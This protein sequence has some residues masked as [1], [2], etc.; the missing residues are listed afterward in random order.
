MANTLQKILARM[1]GQPQAPVAYGTGP[2]NLPGMMAQLPDIQ[3]RQTRAAKLR[4]TQEKFDEMAKKQEKSNYTPTQKGGLYE[5]VAQ[6][7]TDYSGLG[8]ELVGAIGGHFNEK[9]MEREDA[10]LKN[11]S[12]NEQLRVLEQIGQQR[13]R[14]P[15]TPAPAGEPT[16]AALRGYLGM[17]GGDIDKGVFSDAA[18]VSGQIIEK[19]TGEVINR[20][21]D[22]S[23][24][25]TGIIKDPNVKILDPEGEVIQVVDLGGPNVGTGRDVIFGGGQPQPGQPQ[26]GQPQPGQPQRPNTEQTFRDSL[27]ISPEQEAQI[28]LIEAEQGAPLTEQQMVQYLQT[29]DIGLPTPGGQQQPMPQGAPNVPAQMPEPVPGGAQ[30]AAAGAPAP[31]PMSAPVAAPVP[32]VAQGRTIRTPTT[33]DKERDKIRAANEA[34]VPTANSAAIK[35]SATTDAHMTTEHR[36]AARLAVPQVKAA[37]ARTL[38]DVDR[39]MGNEEGLAEMV[40]KAITARAS[41]VPFIGDQLAKGWVGMFNPGTPLADAY[42]AHEQLT[43]KAFL[44]SYEDVLKGTGPISN[45]EGLKGAQA[46]LQSALFQSP[47]VYMNRLQEFRDRA[48]ELEQRSIAAGLG[49]VNPDLIPA[50][51]RPAAAPARM[52]PERRAELQRKYGSKK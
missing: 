26:P 52:S 45:V 46:A 12:Q 30:P 49:P 35:E 41:G 13:A 50:G 1:Q 5:T 6:Y 28:E 38:S 33:F 42:A 19:G 7:R 23:L 51:Q 16:E 37:T 29:G 25:R 8:D 15:G 44:S 18:H 20:M 3:A 14:K 4:R 11:L 43:S 31:I 47:E 27:E 48:L 40:G 32:A 24:Q 22:G 17:L 2:M 36:T 21:S 9:K 34:A 39:L 10:D